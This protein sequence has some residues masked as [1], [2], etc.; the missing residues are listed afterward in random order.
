MFSSA[1][2]RNPYEV[3]E[4]CIAVLL[5]ISS[6][7]SSCRRRTWLSLFGVS[8]HASASLAPSPAAPEHN[9]VR[10]D[11]ARCLYCHD[12]AWPLPAAHAASS[13]E[14]CLAARQQQLYNVIISVLRSDPSFKYTQGFHDFC[15]AVLLVIG[16][17]QEGGGDGGEVLRAFICAVGQKHLRPSMCD[18]NL[19]AASAACFR[20]FRVLFVI[21]KQLAM[22]LQALD[23]NATVCLSWI[24][25]LFTHPLSGNKSDVSEVLDFIFASDDDYI[26]LLSACIIADNSHSLLLIHDGGDAYKAIQECPK[27]SLLPSHRRRKCLCHAL[28]ISLSK[29]KAE[30]DAAS[31][32]ATRAAAAA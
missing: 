32:S 23:V 8:D 5:G 31:L 12:R 25:T 20:V 24:L 3:A 30:S 16:A 13:A 28:Q 21:N 2:L 6:A 29:Y 27:I 17:G 14:S 10:L 15:A 19:E 22:H 11:V 7:A 4:S 26:V 18:A 1:G 9:Q